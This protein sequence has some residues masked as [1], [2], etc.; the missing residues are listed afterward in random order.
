MKCLMNGIVKDIEMPKS[1]TE[2]IISLIPK[3][4]QDLTN[5]KNYRPI[6]LLCADYK[7]FSKILAERLKK[8]YLSILAKNK[9][10][11]YQRDS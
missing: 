5:V 4:G 1:W 6:S 11:F 8:F 9:Q 3:E 2:A 7:L 10:D